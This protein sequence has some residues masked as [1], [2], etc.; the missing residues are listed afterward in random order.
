LPLV[1]TLALGCGGGAGGA[2]RDGG[3]DGADAPATEAGT[4]DGGEADGAPDAEAD[5]PPGDAAAAD[6]GG[7]PADMV[8]VMAACMDR[9][10]APN[11]AGA[12]PLVMYT[13]VEA[14]AWC[15][16]RGKR[17]CFDDEWQTACAGPDG[18]AYPYGDTHVPGQCKRRQGVAHLQP[19]AA[20]RLAPRGV[21][22][23]HR[24][25]ARP[26]RG[27][28]RRRDGGRGRRRPRRVALPGRGGR[29][30]TR[31]ASARPAPTT[32]A[33]TS[34]SGPGAAT[35]ASPSSTAS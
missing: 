25:P 16:A 27:G 29:R 22:P 23:G 13:F 7:C 34:R 4:P 17:L 18:W 20:Q 2:G 11:V 8:P 19:D 30:Q 5:A 32:C 15:A 31:R 28:A 1:L 24:D 6:G 14:E 9:H 26:L 21:E 35:A 12:L 33:A 3:A 10:E